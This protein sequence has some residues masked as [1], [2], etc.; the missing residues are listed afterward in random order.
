MKVTFEG[1]VEMKED[2]K[3]IY[4]VDGQESRPLQG[5][6]EHLAMTA[7]LH[8]QMGSYAY[9]SYKRLRLWFGFS[10]VCNVLMLAVFYWPR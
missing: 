10:L 2:G 3:L 1:R 4:H 6:E 5:L 8:Q 7:L 9:L